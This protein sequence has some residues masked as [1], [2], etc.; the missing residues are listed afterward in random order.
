MKTMGYAQSSISRELAVV[1]QLAGRIVVV[2]RGSIC[3]LGSV[4]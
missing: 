2:Y 4:L 3:E 1:A